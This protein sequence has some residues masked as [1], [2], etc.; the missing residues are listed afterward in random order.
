MKFDTLLGEC[1]KKIG[2]NLCLL[3]GGLMAKAWADEPLFMTSQRWLRIIP[4]AFVM[5]TIAY[6]DRTNIALALPSLSK[7]L[8][9]NA[10]DAGDIAGIFFYGYLI[11]QIPG[12]YLAHRWSAKWCVSILLVFW[13]I[14]AVACGL[15]HTAAQFR[16]ARFMLGV[17]EGGVWPAVLVM[18]S[19]WF[20]RAERARA[21]AFWMLCLPLSVVVSS[22]I[23]GWIIDHWNWRTMLIAEGALPFLWLVIWISFVYD[24]PREA[25]W[26][27]TEERTE[28]ETILR[29]ESEEL[30]PVRPVPLYAALFH[31]TVLIL[32]LV[33]FLMNVGAY[34]YNSWLPSALKKAL[35]TQAT[36]D[37]AASSEKGRANIPAVQ[38][39]LK[40]GALNAVPY[41]I[42]AVAMV[43]VARSSDRTRKR[44][45]HLV[46]GL[47]WAGSFLALSVWAGGSHPVL[48]FAFVT[49]VIGGAWSGLAPF[50]AI[51]AETLPRDVAASSMG[52]IN[53]LGNLGGYFG[54]YVVGY[55]KDLSAG[56]ENFSAA[57]LVLA[58]SFVLGGLAA[59]LLPAQRAASDAGEKR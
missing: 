15:V 40:V 43:M 29:H 9:I 10:K 48:S 35:D 18:L 7:E 33:Y 27:S 4:V 36:A 59:M 6:I 44:R 28:V 57:F 11:L 21:N 39:N 24:H 49:L 25:P 46:R 47:I 19:Q 50:W 58:L 22:P 45:V 23:S 55:V 32:I 42:A 2:A 38:S 1:S 20:P 13:G 34:G 53:A 52:L 17:A 41:L 56:S 30:K 51:P 37:A 26:I 31:P 54:P 3:A 8:G 16:V 5:Y 14:C 12:G